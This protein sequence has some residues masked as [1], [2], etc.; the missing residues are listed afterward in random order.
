MREDF[1]NEIKNDSKITLILDR[2][3]NERK[4]VSYI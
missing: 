1:K 3:K 4:G 2:K